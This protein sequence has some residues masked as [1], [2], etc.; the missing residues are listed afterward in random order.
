MIGRARFPFTVL[1]FGFA[2]LYVPIALVIAYSFNASQLVTVWA[3][4]SLQWW[5]ALL[6]RLQRTLHQGRSGW[7]NSMCEV[8]RT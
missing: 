2:F 1:C 7:W 3:G 5:R 8:P 4:F 6:Q